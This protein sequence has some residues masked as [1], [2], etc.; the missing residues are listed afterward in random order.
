VVKLLTFG[1]RRFFL[2][3]Q[4][5]WH[6]YDLAVAAVGF[7]DVVDTAVLRIMHSGTNA[8]DIITF[9]AI[10]LLGRLARLLRLLRFKVFGE[11]RTMVHGVFMGLRVLFW[12]ITLFG[13]FIYCLG[14]F[15]QSTLGN[16]EQGNKFSDNFRSVPWAMFTLFICFTGGCSASDGT[17]LQ[18]HLAEEFG[19]V[20]MV[21]YIVV[22]L[23]VTIGIFNLMLGLFIDNVFTASR[24]RSQMFRGMDALEMENKLKETLHEL[25]LTTP[26]KSRQKSTVEHVCSSVRSWFQLLL[27]S[28]KSRFQLEART[29][30]DCLHTEFNRLDTD[31]N[32]SSQ[33]FHVWL[34][35]PQLLD[36]LD[37]LDINTSNKAELFDVLDSNQSGA[38]DVRDIAS[39]LMRM[40]GPPQKSDS[41]AALLSVRH[42]V[43]VVRDIHAKL[44]RLVGEDSLG[45][46]LGS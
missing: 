38:L 20:F 9:K 12:A 29:G 10:A 5:Q 17:P 3:A 13:L 23:F 28:S 35:D 43:A 33:V 7:T 37:K 30:A 2:G 24:R 11:L 22:F 4:W 27:N 40:R 6:L 36:L 45:S 21:V 41:V 31:M 26:G 44:D 1:C 19:L 39:G 32:I 46:T 8:D 16:V 25:L 42:V 18:V 15:V 34:S 14:V